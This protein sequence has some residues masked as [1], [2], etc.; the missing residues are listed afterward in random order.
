M[1]T[2][3][4]IKL[5]AVISY[6]AIGFNVLSGLIYTPW[7]IQTIGQD[8]YALY[9][10]AL[11]IINI[12][13]MDFG[14]GSAVTRFLSKFYAE[15]KQ[16][17]ANQ[18]MGIV[19]KVYIGI[20]AIIAVALFV[21]YFLIDTIYPK[22][23]PSEISVFKVLYVIVACYSV[24]SFPCMSFQGV[25]MANEK[26]IAVKLC[27]LGQKVLSVAMIVIFLISGQGVFALVFVHA[28]SNLVFHIVRYL[29]IKSKTKQKTYLR[30]WDGAQA[31]SL[32][33]YSAWVTIMSIAQRCIFNI[34][35][36]LIAALVGS[37]EVTLFSLAA[38]LEG[39]VFLFADAVN[40]MF[41]PKISR[42]LATDTP[43]DSLNALMCKV[44]KFHVYTMGLLIVGF[45]GIGRQFIE[46][47]LGPGNE[48][49]YYCALL[50][51]VPSLID[52]PQQVA[53][54]S[55]LA[56]NI[57]KEQAVIYLIMAA[58]NIALS[59]ILI[60][61]LGAIGA[62]VAICVAYLIRTL[63]F[64]LL[65]GKKL[66]IRLSGYFKGCYLKWSVPAILAVLAGLILTS[67]F[68]NVTI[69][70]FLLS[71]F[72]TVAIYAVAALLM[73][74]MDLRKIKNRLLSR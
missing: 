31:K 54:T 45:A 42:I 55:L 74:E 2:S 68:K 12:F 14:I 30:Q 43:G 29:I 1:N 15:N 37:I 8:Q 35:P 71:G 62:A 38:T 10:L 53:K 9:A 51:I 33:G 63:L 44:G 73:G 61:W 19:Y 3:K 27:N 16:E 23:T 17:E 60:P 6:I 26:F 4:Q 50:L 39:Y 34:M 7:M 20:A 21:F 57:M 49:V 46:L 11:S 64:N 65:Y 48:I 25:L 41:M 72:S 66:P 40:G 69:W 32:F 67:V 24:I 18:F 22:L 56:L 36:S 47:W 58:V 52:V 70:S 59:V 28:V 5:G 13:L